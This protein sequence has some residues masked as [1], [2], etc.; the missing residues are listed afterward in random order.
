MPAFH[1]CPVVILITVAQIYKY[2]QN[3]DQT[4]DPRGYQL[5]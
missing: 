3:Q 4:G 5:R 1:E 2:L